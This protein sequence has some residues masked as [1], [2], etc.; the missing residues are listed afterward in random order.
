MKK[1]S[2]K[3]D[4][5]KPNWTGPYEVAERIGDN[6]YY[7]QKGSGNNK[8]VLKSKYNST[9]LKMYMERSGGMF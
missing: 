4:K 7:L 2:K 6:N 3:G 1:L 9:R 8:V 5:L